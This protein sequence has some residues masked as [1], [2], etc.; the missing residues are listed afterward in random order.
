M[1]RPLRVLAIGHSYTIATNR[2][3]IREVAR[4]PA[5][6]IT[7]A[8]PNFF[9]GDLRSLNLDP[10]PEGSPVKMVGVDVKWS[11]L[12]HLFRYDDA[13]LRQLMRDGS[14]DVVH[15]WEE[16][17]IYAGYQIAR[18][19]DSLPARF[20]FRTAQNYSKLYPPPFGYFERRTLARAQGWLAGGTLVRQAML[21]RGY[22]ADQG[23]VITLAVD[24]DEFRPVDPEARAAVVRELELSPPVIG[25]VGRLTSAKGLDILMRAMELI[26][27]STPWSLLLLGSGPYEEKI[28]GWA[29]RNGWGD[30]VRIKL[31]KHHEVPRY[32]TAMDIMV[33]PS[34]TTRNW[35]EQFGRM[36]IEA[37]ACGIPVVGSDS[38]EL[39]HVIGDAGRVLP[40][41]DARAWAQTIEELITDGQVRAQLADKGLERVKHYTVSTVSKQ[42]RNF[43]NWLAAQRCS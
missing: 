40:E 8:A 7:V 20:S 4:D 39:P 26:G 41:R 19:L 14:F 18:A 11:G 35:R 13:A 24:L 6:D 15:A 28:N 17:Y 38:G 33:A 22:P 36:I 5:F 42:F 23:R 9:K 10:E 37:F 3:L 27:A 16:P 30:R 32:L 1:T 25:Y 31:A 34:Q 12:I 2:A 43:F 29:K 21:K